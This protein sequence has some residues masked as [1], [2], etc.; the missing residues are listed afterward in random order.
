MIARA[1]VI[2]VWVGEPVQSTGAQRWRWPRPRLSQ[3]RKRGRALQQVWGGG[4][5]G[6][7]P[8]P[9]QFPGSHLLQLIWAWCGHSYQATIFFPLLLPF[10]SHLP[11]LPGCYLRRRH[12]ISWAAWAPPVHRHPCHAGWGGE[13]WTCCK[14]ATAASSRSSLE[15]ASMLSPRERDEA[16]WK[17]EEGGGGVAAMVTWA[18]RAPN[19]KAGPACTS[20]EIEGVMVRCPEKMSRGPPWL[21]TALMIAQVRIYYQSYQ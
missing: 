9:P 12:L 4:Q 13:S 19:T 11:L 16:A 5:R 15:K 20:P 6:I 17:T 8:P 10:K 7:S 18:Q 2:G 3:V 14:V 1:I 21:S